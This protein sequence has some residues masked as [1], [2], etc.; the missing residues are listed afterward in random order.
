MRPLQQVLDIK[1]G[2]ALAGVTQRQIAA[3]LEID[4]GMVSRVITGNL[5]GF[6]ASEATVTLVQATI[7]EAVGRDVFNGSE[8]GSKEGTG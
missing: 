1:Y 4:P 8:G 7:N 5:E 3:A 2:L 6:P